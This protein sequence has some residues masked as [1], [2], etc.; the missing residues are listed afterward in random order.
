MVPALYLE[1]SREEGSSAST[2]PG[3][4]QRGREWYQH[5]NWSIAERKGVASALYL[6]SIAERKGG[7]PALYL[8]YSR[9][10]GRSTS[11]VPGV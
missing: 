3:V 8:E 5:C 10:E 2:V 4:L 7:V 1:Y 6:E 9:E 11:T